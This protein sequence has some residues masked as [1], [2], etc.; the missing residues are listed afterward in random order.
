VVRPAADRPAQGACGS[1]VPPKVLNT[2]ICGLF[3][4]GFLSCDRWRYSG[5]LLGDVGVT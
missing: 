4:T 3:W 1:G 5:S 2:K